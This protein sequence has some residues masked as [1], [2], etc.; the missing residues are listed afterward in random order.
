MSSIIFQ[1]LLEKSISMS[2]SSCSDFFQCPPKRKPVKP[3]RKV[4]GQAK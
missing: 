1:G 3:Q 2:W 4:V